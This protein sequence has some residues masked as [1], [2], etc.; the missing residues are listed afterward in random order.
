MLR[1]KPHRVG[2]AAMEFAFVLPLLMILLLGGIDFGRFPQTHLAVINAA[3]AGAAYGS[4][5][6]YT[7]STAT[8]WNAAVRKAVNDEM[9]NLAGYDSTKLTLAISLGTDSEGNSF[10]T[11][12]VSYPFTPLLKWPTYATVLTLRQVAAMR[13]IRG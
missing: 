13:S 10:V 11:V 5:H 3:R 9:S 2:A 8:V 12:D 1:Q 7:P 6:P 4:T